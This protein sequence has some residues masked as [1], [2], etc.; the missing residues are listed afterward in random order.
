MEGEFKLFYYSTEVPCLINPHIALVPNSDLVAELPFILMHPKPED[1]E[2][3]PQVSNP[4]LSL[5]PSDAA[6][7][8]QSNGGGIGASNDDPNCNND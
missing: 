3:L 8:G 2:P 5:K 4:R 7:D 6:G 1:D